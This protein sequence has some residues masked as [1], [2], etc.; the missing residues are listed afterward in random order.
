MY[1]H[2]VF[3]GPDGKEYEWKLGT[4]ACNVIS[5]HSPTVAYW[6]HDRCSFPFRF[7]IAVSQ[8]WFKASSGILSRPNLCHH[9][10]GS[11]VLF[12]NFSRRTTYGWPYT[13]HIHFCRKN[14]DGVENG[15]RH[16]RLILHA[17]TQLAN[18]LW[19]CIIPP[20]MFSSLII[21]YRPITP[22]FLL[23]PIPF[24]LCSFLSFQSSFL[25]SNSLSFLS[26]SY[27]SFLFSFLS[28]PSSHSPS[29]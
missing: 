29:E 16:Q 4:N 9:R 20:W 23:I 25:L 7:G 28:V 8:E 5:D 27:I 11:P 13:G 17:Q 10:R 21:W 14:S 12:G 3:T 1:S 2:R 19:K 24:I 6:I 18:R 22:H 15:I 26:L